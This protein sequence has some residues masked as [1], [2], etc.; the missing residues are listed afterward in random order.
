MSF[1]RNLLLATL[2]CALMLTLSSAAL[3]DTGNGTNMSVNGTATVSL[4]PDYA[5]VTAGY[6][7]QNIDIRFAREETALKMDG[8]IK[9]LTA[10]GIDD[11]DIATSSF[12]VESMYDYSKN[13]SEVVGYRVNSSVTITVRDIERVAAV[14][15]AVF[16]AGSNQSYGLEFRSTKEG[17]AYR[18]ALKTAIA[19]AKEKATLMAEAAGVPLG[20][21]VAI[22]ENQSGYSPMPQYANV[23][24]EMA[25]SSKAAGLGDSVMAGMLEVAAQVVLQY[26]LGE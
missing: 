10:L 18:E 19:V 12:T 23:R 8:I 21:L 20:R 1:L 14:L 3:A 13:Y 15:N 4:E 22:N 9:S 25:D 11:K 7:S 26:E 6:A 2:V 5:R 17:E 16:E 24:G